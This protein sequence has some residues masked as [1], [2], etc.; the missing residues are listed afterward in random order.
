MSRGFFK[1]ARFG[2]DF[3]NL[4]DNVVDDPYG[5]KRRCERCDAWLCSQNKGDTCYPCRRNPTR[6]PSLSVKQEDGK[7]EAYQEDEQTAT[8]RVEICRR[9]SVS[10]EEVLDFAKRPRNNGLAFARC[11]LAYFLV[12]YLEKSVAEVTRIMRMSS[13]STAE[14]CY[15][16]GKAIIALDR[17]ARQIIAEVKK[18][19]FRTV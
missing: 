18:I 17:Q 12:K 11:L 1:S 4:P 14:S 7:R 15:R 10:S 13:Q 2:P 3:I 16:R 8:A 9:Y 19:V 6:P 5:P